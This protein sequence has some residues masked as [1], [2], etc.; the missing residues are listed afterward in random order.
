MTECRKAWVEPEL[1]VLVRSKPEED[2]LGGCKVFFETNYGASG[3]YGTCSINTCLN[4][5]TGIT[6][7]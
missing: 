5:C 1:I 2:V 7:S 4:P 6:G 3:T